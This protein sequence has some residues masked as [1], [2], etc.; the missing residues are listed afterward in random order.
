MHERDRQTDHETVT[1]IATGEMAI[2]MLV[3]EYLRRLQCVLSFSSLCPLPQCSLWLS[4][5]RVLYHG[6][7]HT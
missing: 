2:T 3:K 1:S 5:R 7:P 4:Q 6:Q